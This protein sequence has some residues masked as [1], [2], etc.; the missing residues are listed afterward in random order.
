MSGITKRIVV[1]IAAFLCLSHALIIAMARV[2]GDPNYKSY[3][4]GYKLDQTVEDLLMASGGGLEKLQQ[5]QDYL[6]DY[7]IIVYDGLSPDRLTFTGNC[8]S[9]K[10][11]YLLYDAD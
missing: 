5:F 6:S 4:D 7:I 11:F 9:N 3:R 1:V 2:N 10:R 8:L